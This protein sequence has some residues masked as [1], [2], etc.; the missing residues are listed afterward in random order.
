[1]VPHTLKW[2]AAAGLVL[3]TTGQGGTSASGASATPAPTKSLSGAAVVTDDNPYVELYKLRVEESESNLHRAQALADLANSKLE[4]GRRLVYSAA[5][6]QEDYDTLVSDATVAASDT[7]L[8]KKKIDE[9]KAYL[10]IIEAL[11]K[12][13]VS[14]PLC[15]YDMQ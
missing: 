1:M 2:I 6:S 9:A 13:G 15:T 3:A 10:R 12:R 7:E 8:A 11:V 5:M 14:I 4:R